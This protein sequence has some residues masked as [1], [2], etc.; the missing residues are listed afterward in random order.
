MLCRVVAQLQNVFQAADDGSS[1]DNDD[2][3]D[4]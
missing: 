2:N 4:E 3:S 1:D